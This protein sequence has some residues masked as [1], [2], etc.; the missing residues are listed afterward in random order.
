MKLS[1]FIL[2]N[3]QEKKSTVLHRGVLLAKR[4]SVDSMVFLFQL[5]SYYVEAY[6][7]SANKAIEEYRMFENIGVL[8]PYLDAI[9]LD[10]LL[11]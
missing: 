4:S 11:N 3:E 5:G 7:N 1:E 6:C 8:Q 10:Q 2:L 9:P